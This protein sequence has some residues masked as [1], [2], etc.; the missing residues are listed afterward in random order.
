MRLAHLARETPASTLVERM[1][2]VCLGMRTHAMVA[3]PG[4]ARSLQGRRPQSRCL[5]YE[6]F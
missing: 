5:G 2:A 1:I 4:A 3:Q 6:A